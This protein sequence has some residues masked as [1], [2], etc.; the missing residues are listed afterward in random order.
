MK[1]RVKSAAM[2]KSTTSLS[3][4]TEAP[5][6]LLP[7]PVVTQK[8]A[9]PEPMVT[10]QRLMDSVPSSP[11]RPSS[12]PPIHTLLSGDGVRN[13]I[14]PDVLVSPANSTQIIADRSDNF[15]GKIKIV[16]G[17]E[18]EEASHAGFPN[19]VTSVTSTSQSL[20]HVPRPTHDPHI[21]QRIAAKIA[22]ADIQ[23][24]S[25]PK[26]RAPLPPVEASP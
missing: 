21:T 17:N 3:N 1:G 20:D 7:E 12:D 5:E 13:G 11:K 9:V 26:F 18:Q 19:G 8:Q 25:P 4:A 24:P 16:N 22:L 6:Q 14:A 23:M 2:L 10:H 15:P